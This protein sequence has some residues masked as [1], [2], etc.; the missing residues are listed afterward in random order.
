MGNYFEKNNIK[1]KLTYLNVIHLA[2]SL[3]KPREVK[4]RPR[5]KCP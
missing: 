3:F 5:P 1:I 4:I 2:L